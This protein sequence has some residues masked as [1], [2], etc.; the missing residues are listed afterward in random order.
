M[1]K[2]NGQTDSPLKIKLKSELL[3][4]RWGASEVAMGGRIPMEVST[5]FVADGSA[6]KFEIKNKEGGIIDSVEGK[7]Y[8]NFY[9]GLFALTK[10]NKTGGM[11]FEAELPDHSLKGKSGLVKV[12]PPIKITELKLQDDKGKDLEDISQESSLK[13]VSKVDGAPDASTCTFYL[14]L[15]VQDHPG[16]LVFK[17]KSKVTDGKAQCLW[18]LKPLDQEPTISGQKDLDKSAQKY[19]PPKYYFELHCLGASATSE[20]TDY[21]S[22]SEIDFGAIRGKATILTP[23]GSE[24]IETI[25]KDGIIKLKKPKAGS[26]TVKN[27]E[28]EA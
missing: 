2:F 25:P 23:D 19:I 5:A 13:M 8:A 3:E 27:V 18:K 16:L 20:T 9:R 28:P 6:V 7:I 4:A 10:A 1:A 22:W 11:F 15:K 12:L 26:F 24:I 14:Y 21:V 17:G